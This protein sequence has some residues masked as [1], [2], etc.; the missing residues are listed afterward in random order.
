MYYYDD[1]P[2]FK[3]W[4]VRTY[5]VLRKNH[6]MI[7]SAQDAINA[8]DRCR[9]GFVRNSGKITMPIELYRAGGLGIYTIYKK[10]GGIVTIEQIR[11]LCIKFDHNFHE[12]F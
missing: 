7:Y 9:D 5:H 1:F 4:M 3:P 8:G 10:L 12:I 2:I 11:E 6:I